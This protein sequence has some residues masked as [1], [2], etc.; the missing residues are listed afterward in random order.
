MK[1]THRLIHEESGFTLVESLVGIV[2]VVGVLL[3][4]IACVGF[5][6]ARDPSGGLR[7]ASI[8][9]RNEIARVESGNLLQNETRSIERGLMLIRTIEPRGNLRCIVV[10]ICDKTSNRQILVIEKDVLIQ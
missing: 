3:P 10:T 4:L 7:M 1:S 9:A 6:V 8:V 2:L 5:F